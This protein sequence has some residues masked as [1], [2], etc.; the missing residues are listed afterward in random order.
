MNGVVARDRSLDL[1]RGVAIVSMTFSHL[2]PLSVASKVIHLGPSVDGASGFVLMS[3]LVLGLVQHGRIR[4]AGVRG[5]WQQMVKRAAKLYVIQIVLVTA[6]LLAALLPTAADWMPT[7]ASEGGIGPSIFKLLTLQL[8]PNYVNILSMYVILMILGAGS[9]VLLARSRPWI[10]ATSS[11]VVYV[12]SQVF[13]T[14]TELPATAT[15]SPY[16]N[17]G[18]WQ[19]L[20]VSAFMIG[21]Y[22]KRYDLAVMLTRKVPVLIAAGVFT[23]V[24]LR[25]VNVKLNVFPRLEAS[26]SWLFTKGDAGPLWVAMAWATFVLLYALLFRVPQI[27][28]SRWASPIDTIGRGSLHAFVILTAFCIATPILGGNIES[29]TAVFVAVLSLIV[30]Y[31]WCTYRDRRRARNRLGPV[32]RVA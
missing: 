25:S 26:I 30:M 1:L 13:P 8:N 2:A 19:L 31:G 10:V 3:G 22:W 16:F 21:W 4:T 24:T 5:A 32:V 29:S 15:S 28:A 7:I 20:F 6:V 12:I 9:V 18:A 11:V 27:A 17:W 14:F 23:L